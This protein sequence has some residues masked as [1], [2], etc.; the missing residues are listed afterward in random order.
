MKRVAVGESDLLLTLFTEK[1][2]IVS[3]AARTARSSS[4]RFGSLEPMHL[5]RVAIDERQGADVGALVEATIA[6]ARV[7][8]T[9]DLDALE[10][11]G[12]ALRWARR[13]APPHTSEPA[14]FDELNEL[15]D[16]LDEEPRAPL[17]RLA[18]SGLRVLGAVGWGLDLERC[19]VCG[20]PCREGAAAYVDATRGGLVCRA[21]GGA[22]VVLS[23]EQRARLV[24][25]RAGEGMLLEDDVERALELVEDALAAHVAPARDRPDSRR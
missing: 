3:V 18:A 13:A 15:L 12:R 11:A 9:S 16:A 4:K 14:L 10:A 6:R 21:C 22:R 8:L 2:G 5:L 17:A 7:R 20:K 23:G 19:V 24:A 25:A 1:K